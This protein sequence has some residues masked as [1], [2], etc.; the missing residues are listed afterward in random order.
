MLERRRLRAYTQRAGCDHGHHA[1]GRAPDD[2][3]EN[4]RVHVV[5]TSTPSH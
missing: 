1:Y 3:R 5:L 4:D 2:D